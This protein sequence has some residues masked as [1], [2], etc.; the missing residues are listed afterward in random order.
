M[1]WGEPVAVR[2]ARVGVRGGGPSREMM[3]W[4]SREDCRIV[5]CRVNSRNGEGGGEWQVKDHTQMPS[6][7]AS[8]PSARG[9]RRPG[10]WPAGRACRIGVMLLLGNAQTTCLPRFGTW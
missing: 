8:Q 1:A 5:N 2:V 9:W 4:R 10:W 7:R 3:G 6:L